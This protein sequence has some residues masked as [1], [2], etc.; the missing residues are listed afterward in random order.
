M[1]DGLILCGA[2]LTLGADD[3]ILAGLLDVRG[4]GAMRSAVPSAH[5]NIAL[6]ATS[7]MKWVDFLYSC[8]AT[9]KPFVL[10]LVFNSNYNWQLVFKELDALTLTWPIQD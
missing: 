3:E 5:Q 7:G 10:S 4:L 9:C 8:I 1:A 2:A 6:D